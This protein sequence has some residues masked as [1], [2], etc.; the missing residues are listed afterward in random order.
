MKEVCENYIVNVPLGVSFYM[1]F[2]SGIMAI[3]VHSF[4]KHY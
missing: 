2:M 1:I 4:E 3:S